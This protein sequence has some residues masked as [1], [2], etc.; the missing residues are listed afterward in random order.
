VL[1]N[2]LSNAAKYSPVRTEVNV[3]VDET[4]EGVRIRVLDGGPGI[5][6]AEAGR[7][8]EL[9]YRSPSTASTAGGA[10]IGLYVCRVLVE[11]MG[12]RIWAAARP[13]GGS[14]FGFVLQR[15]EDS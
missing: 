13:E 3:M 1:R 10:G 4:T 9:Y 2:L 11:A 5:D 8:F 15:D 6:P 12:G 14:E 7:L